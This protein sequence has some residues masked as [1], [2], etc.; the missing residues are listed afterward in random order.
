MQRKGNLDK[1]LRE[2]YEDHSLRFLDWT[3]RF[4]IERTYIGRFLLYIEEKFQIRRFS[5]IFLF[6]L[7]LAWTLTFEVRTPL[8]Y[9]VGDVAKTDLY[10]PVSFEMVDEVTTEEKR[11]RAEMSVPVIFDFDPAVFERVSGAVY[12][13]FRVARNQL[14]NVKWPARAG[15]RE[16]VVKEFFIHKGEFEKEIG[17]QLPD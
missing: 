13:A 2:N 1:H 11:V 7:L 4:G 3:H 10:S 5:F 12:R 9:Q 17:A 6:C 16:E 14:K 15:E 8:N